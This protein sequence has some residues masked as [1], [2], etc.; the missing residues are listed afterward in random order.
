LALVCA[1][2]DFGCC[3]VSDGVEISAFK[4]VYEAGFCRRVKSAERKGNFHGHRML[5]FVTVEDV[6]KF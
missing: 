3:C 4:K 2:S 1:A 6:L 5:W